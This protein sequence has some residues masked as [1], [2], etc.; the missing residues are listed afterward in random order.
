MG[1]SIPRD[2]YDVD[3]FHPRFEGR[4]PDTE[5]SGL[6]LIRVHRFYPAVQKLVKNRRYDSV[7]H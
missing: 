6:R 5:K 2:R 3:I 4:G 7:N 1:E